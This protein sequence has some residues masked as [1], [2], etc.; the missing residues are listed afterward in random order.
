[1]FTRVRTLFNELTS[2]AVALID[3]GDAELKKADIGRL[4]SLVEQAELED[5]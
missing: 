1:M 2:R 3:G 5:K 4:R